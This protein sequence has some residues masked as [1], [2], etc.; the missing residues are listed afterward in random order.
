MTVEQKM[1]AK[2][3]LACVTQSQT[4]NSS[5]LSSPTTRYVAGVSVAAKLVAAA[6]AAAPDPIRF[7]QSIDI[8][9]GGIAEPVGIGVNAM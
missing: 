2:A 8:A 5:R 7:A 9:L 6:A 4:A 1:L 3:Q